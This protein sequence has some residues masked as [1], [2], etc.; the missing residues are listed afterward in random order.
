[1]LKNQ[2]R[3]KFYLLFLDIFLLLFSFL[4]TLI[5][6]PGPLH[7]WTGQ[8][9]SCILNCLSSYIFFSLIIVVIFF[10]NNLY[11]RNI[12]VT[13]YR[14]FILILKS[15]VIGIL[16]CVVILVFY[17]PDF[18]ME[19]GKQIFLY[20]FFISLALL[21][22][23]RAMFMKQVLFFL[24]Q[25]NLY[26]Q[27]VLIVGADEPGKYVAGQLSSDRF[28]NYHIAGFLDD[29]KEP[30][31]PVI[32]GHKN[33]GRLK[34]LD[35]LIIELDI[36]EI[37]IAIHKAPYTRLIRILEACLKTGCVVRVYSDLLE[38]VTSK[39][40][41]ES[42]AGIPLVMLAQ[43]TRK[44]ATYPFKRTFD[45]T[46]SLT[47]LIVLSPLF[48]L[49]A[50]GIKLSSPGPV[51]FKQTRI[52]H[53]GRPFTFYKF[54]SMHCGEA[55]TQHK[56]FVQNFIKESAGEKESAGDEIKVFKMTND[57]RI[58]P[59]GRF[60]RKTSLD[61]F[62]Q[63]YNVLK[64]DMSLVGPRPCLPYEW[65]IYDSWH[66]E[67]LNCLPGCTG[68]WQALGRSTVNFQEMVVLDLYYVSNMSILLDIRIIVNTFPAI[69]LGKGGF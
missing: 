49:I 40:N 52:G 28:F 37:I 69:F 66:K 4:L 17:N 7:Q 9:L 47:A 21:T 12:L 1:M 46:A 36:D 6:M 22:L 32:E 20:F 59:F 8:S 50:L 29:Y 27:K 26:P 62:P 30:G 63:F 56:E 23:V 57:P 65:E 43:S 15:L 34:D 39:I 11:K 5:L 41:V 48:A 54:R 16:L 44:T 18:L 53:E 61:E 14:Q 64:G 68:I 35:R 42:Y 3:F 45:F 25:K 55:C 13:R 24:H 31:T 10:F 19:H 38:I 2:P 58:F 67:R 60:I 33:L 51:I